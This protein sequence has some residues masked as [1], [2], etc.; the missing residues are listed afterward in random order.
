MRDQ[1][2]QVV[3]KDCARRKQGH[4]RI[5]DKLKVRKA[6][7]ADQSCRTPRQ[8]KADPKAKA[9]AAAAKVVTWQQLE[10]TN[11]RMSV[12]HS[13]SIYVLLYVLPMSYDICHLCH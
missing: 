10:V 6:A 11:L 13:M 2:E 7:K 9:K 3:S 4:P 5:A 8:A 12:S 1:G